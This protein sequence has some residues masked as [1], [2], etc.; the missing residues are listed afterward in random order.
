MLFQER[1]ALEMQH[2]NKISCE[3]SRYEKM[4]QEKEELNRKWNEEARYFFNRILTDWL[5]V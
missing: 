4:V 3:L 5:Q 2:K 1:R